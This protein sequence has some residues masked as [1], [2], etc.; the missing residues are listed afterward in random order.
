[1]EL[2]CS[3]HFGVTM[4]THEL[5]VFGFVCIVPH[6]VCLQCG[7]T[8]IHIYTHIAHTLGHAHCEKDHSQNVLFCPAYLSFKN[9]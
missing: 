6:F 2:I 4:L 7:K 9:D 3:Y 1:M 8:V 5:H